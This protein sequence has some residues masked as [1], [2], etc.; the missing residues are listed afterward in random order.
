MWVYLIS[1]N[2]EGADPSYGWGWWQS[3]PPIISLLFFFSNA[4]F[5]PC[6]PPPFGLSLKPQRRLSSSTISASICS[7]F[8]AICCSSSRQCV[9]LRC[10]HRLGYSQHHHFLSGCCLCRQR[11]TCTAT[12]FFHLVTSFF[13]CGCVQKVAC[14]WLMRLSR[15]SSVGG[16]GSCRSCW[17]TG[18]RHLGFLLLVF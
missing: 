13:L 5:P 9:E 1:I 14:G 7:L 12:G 18:S 4:A 3:I 6:S 16:L 11:C 2:S 17:C 10:S 8:T 15:H